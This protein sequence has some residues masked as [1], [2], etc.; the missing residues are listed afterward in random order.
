MR[1]FICDLKEFQEFIKSVPNPSLFRGQSN[2]LDRLIPGIGR[3]HP[4]YAVS[5]ELERAL[6]SQFKIRSVPHLTHKPITDWDWLVMAQHYGLKTRLL[7]W[8]TDWRVALYFATLPHQEMHRVPFSVFVNHSPALTPYETLPENAFQCK[9]DY[10]FQPPHFDNRI[11]GQ[12]A[13]MS[14]HW[15]PYRPVENEEIIQFSFYPYSEQRREIATFLAT[16]R[17]TAAELMPGLD[18][19][20]RTLVDEPRITAQIDLPPP[21][22]ELGWIRVPKSATGMKVGTVRKVLLRRKTLALA[23]EWFTVEKLIGIPCFCGGKAFGFLKYADRSLQHFTF[24]A[25]DGLSVRLVSD[26]DE[27]FEAITLAKEHIAQLMPEEP[28]FVR[29]HIG[30]VKRLPNA[31]NSSRRSRR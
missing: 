5:P 10:Y 23:L 26:T 1:E 17:I 19:I 6:F 14:A 30:D 15:N 12:A 13:F 27:I 24:L 20:C 9:S 25:P 16:A 22:S 28:M 7:D 31:L 3:E 21:P 11:S 29:P 8:T 2:A 18:G 4:N